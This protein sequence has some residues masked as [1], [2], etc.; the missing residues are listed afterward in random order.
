LTIGPIGRLR[1]MGVDFV[2]LL[3]QVVMLAVTAATSPPETVVVANMTAVDLD[4]VER[5]V[6][7][8]DGEG[9]DEDAEIEGDDGS[10][11]HE[12]MERHDTEEEEDKSTVVRVGVTETMRTLW[13]SDAPL[14]RRFR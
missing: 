13:N 1:M 7:M 6:T 11:H 14:L 10:E 2:I 12:M 3:L 4:R 8:E 5:G 9:V